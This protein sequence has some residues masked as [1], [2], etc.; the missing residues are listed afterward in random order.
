MGIGCFDDSAYDRELERQVDEY[1]EEDSDGD[2]FDLSDELYE[3]YRDW[4]NE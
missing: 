4:E 1:C 2:E 3:Q